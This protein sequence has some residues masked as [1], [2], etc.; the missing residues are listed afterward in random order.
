MNLFSKVATTLGLGLVVSGAA[1]V[2]DPGQAQA[3][4]IPL[5]MIGNC[6][7]QDPTDTSANFRMS[8]NGQFNMTLTNGTRLNTPMAQKDGWTL[9]RPY[10]WVQN[11]RFACDVMS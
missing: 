3:R 8:P 9:F 1:L 2:I 6:Q 10:G 5:H 7:V 4:Q 11:G